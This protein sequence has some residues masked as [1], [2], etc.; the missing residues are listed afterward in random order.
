MKNTV[1]NTNFNTLFM[2]DSLNLVEPILT[3][4]LLLRIALLHF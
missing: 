3:L 1:S 2:W 4:T